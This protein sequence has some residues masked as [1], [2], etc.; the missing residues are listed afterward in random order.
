MKKFLEKLKLVQYFNS[1]LTMSKDEFMEM[2]KEKIDQEKLGFLSDSFDAWTS[3]KNNFKGVF[4]NDKIIFKGRQSFFNKLSNIPQATITF[5]ENYKNT[6][7]ITKLSG[8]RGQLLIM[9]IFVLIANLFV[10]ILIMNSRIPFQPIFPTI[11]GL[12]S[13]LLFVYMFARIG[14]SGLRKKISQELYKIES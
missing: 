14:I 12:T 3:H 8:L 10:L 6:T 4:T 13:M 5:Q 11:F 1:E 9:L 2:M 7:V